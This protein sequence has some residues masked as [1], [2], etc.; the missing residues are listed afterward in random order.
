MTVVAVSPLALPSVWGYRDRRQQS[1]PKRG[2]LL[3]DGAV[4]PYSMGGHTPAQGE[5]CYLSPVSCIEQCCWRGEDVDL[6]GWLG[7]HP[8]Y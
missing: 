3:E 6:D 5:K 1:C 7:W 2:S 4:A 8:L